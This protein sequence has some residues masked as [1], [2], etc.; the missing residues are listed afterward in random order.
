MANTLVKTEQG[1]V[2]GLEEGNAR[3]WK[4]IPFA[5]KPV[6]ELRFQPPEVHESWEGALDCS[7]FGPICPQNPEVAAMLGA[8]A[9]NMS[10]DCLYLN[11]W[12]P[13][14]EKE[15][16]PV[17]VWIHGGA[18]RAG[19]GS[20]PL[21]DGSAFAENG[22][23]IVV[24][25]N[26]RLGAFGFLHLAGLD[27]GYTGNV[28]LLDQIAALKW[29]RENIK[30][31]GGNPDEVTIFGESAGSMS[32]AS[33]L[34]MP[35]AEGLFKRAI[36]ESGAEQVLPARSAAAV[37]EAML[38]ELGVDKQGLTSLKDISAEKI[39]EAA[40]K[41]NQGAG[42]SMLF[43]PVVDGD[44][45]P[46]YPQKAIS[47]GAAKDVPIIIGTNH[48]EGAFFF[49]PGSKPMPEQVRNATMMKMAGR[50]LFDKIKDQYSATIEG[51]AQFMTDFV[52]WKPSIN[53][54][55]A[56]AKHA[57]VWMYRFDWH[58]P[59]HP[60]VAKASHGLE[61]PFVFTHY[62]YLKRL[63]VDVDEGVKNL[64][65]QMQDA[66]ISFAKTG[67]PNA[68]GSGLRWP[69]Y[70]TEVRSTIVFNRESEVVED[71]DGEKRRLVMEDN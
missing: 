50:E 35:A 39:I 19:S 6:G 71:P 28:G 12:A 24:T 10:E 61:I 51:Q 16:L 47:E 60:V 18:F 49:R 4:G 53:Y 3:V 21:Y 22:D 44:T 67:D 32:I 70:N 5:K 29:V 63:E 40:E 65:R 9:V 36:M 45:L 57:P 17:M 62:G 68:G 38:D 1:L 66:W 30:A 64:A 31:F 26:Y 41:V 34:T 52:F 7:S 25:L 13:M 11:V 15:N 58:I 33:L 59:D 8:P 69:T 46:D 55:E 48:D 2:Q 20:S 56:Q 14:G 23:V 37:A 43:Q 27:G 54:A 42:L